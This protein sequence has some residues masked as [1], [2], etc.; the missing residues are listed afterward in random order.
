MTNNFNVYDQFELASVGT[1]PTHIYDFAQSSANFV[2][3]SSYNSV[4]NIKNKVQQTTN[5][6]TVSGDT[7]VRNIVFGDP[8]GSNNYGP[9][10]T[11]TTVTGGLTQNATLTS[12]FL[13]VSDNGIEKTVPLI[14]NNAY[15]TLQGQ[16]GSR[17]Y[18]SGFIELSFKTNNQNCILAYGVGTQQT[19]AYEQVTSTDYVADQVGSGSTSLTISIIDGKAAISYRDD[20]GINTIAFDVI[21][22]KNIADNEW[23]HVVFNITRPGIL[24]NDSTYT[25]SREIEIWVDG[26]LDKKDSDVIKNKQIFFP[27]ISTLF[28][29]PNNLYSF[30]GAFRTFALRSNYPLTQ[31]EIQEHYAYWNYDGENSARKNIK[32]DTASGELSTPTVSVNKKRALKLFWNGIENKN[33][34]ELDDNYIINSY[35]VTHKN[36]NSV[37]ETHN[38]DLANSKTLNVLTDVR[39]AM[40]ENVLVWGPTMQ[41]TNTNQYNPNNITTNSGLFSGKI[42]NMTFSGVKLIDGD[43][44]LLTNQIDYSENGVWVYNGESSPLT[45]PSD[46]NSVE[47]ISNAVVYVTEGLETGTYWILESNPVSFSQPQKWTKLNGK[48]EN[49]IY[50]QPF[51]SSKWSYENGEERFIDLENDIDISQFDLIVFMNYPDRFEDIRDNFPNDGQVKI[52]YDKFI[53]SLRNVVAQGASLYVSSPLLAADLGII[54]NYYFADQEVEDSDAQSAAINPFEF[55]ED[56]N[57]YFDTHRVNQYALVTEVPGLTDKATYILTDFINY[58]PTDV[59]KQEQYHAKYAY[60]PLGI[61]EGNEFIIPSL[62]LRKA[63]D[64]SNLA[65]AGANRKGTKP[66]TMLEP[67]HVNTGTP[68]TQMQNTYYNGSTAIDNP[69][70]DDITTLIVHDGQLLNGQPVLGKIFM[71]LVEDGYT[72]SREEYNKAVIQVLPESDINETTQ[73][74]AWQYSTSRLNRLPRRANISGLTEFGQTT[75]TNGGGGPLIQAPSNS[76]NGVVRSKTD[77]GNANYQS[78]LYPTEA[79]EI[80]PTQEIPVLSMTWLG[81]QWLAE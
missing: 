46:A 29:N 54:N 49:T 75:P 68:V 34:I 74:R 11:G 3:K 47:K 23:H 71:N 8:E 50:S 51:F 80:Y 6:T 73:T 4:W 36:N 65:G 13:L 70:D 20:Y 19:P 56:A 39:V 5:M 35:S 44:I 9:V 43:R 18:R 78:D 59:N 77:F 16:F 41:T 31:E 63:T 45:R 26:K 37:T 69:H 66:M 15:V 58:V 7:G 72:M 81:L 2:N 55:S 40:T 53:D 42:L 22:N 57:Q 12:D 32:L 30:S 14:S 67:H 60:R 21:G 27:E 62:A 76:S 38:V 10:F 25:D 79:E 52:K 28:G 48:P 64:N 1:S 17:A 33:G 24:K 61:K